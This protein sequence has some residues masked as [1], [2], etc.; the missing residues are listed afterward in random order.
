[1]SATT[2]RDQNS[3]L[4]MFEADGGS[5]HAAI[6][7]NGLPVAACTRPTKL[8]A[9]TAAEERFEAWKGRRRA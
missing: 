6:W 9:K 8:E 5:W 3:R 2:R 1:M 7:V 4:I